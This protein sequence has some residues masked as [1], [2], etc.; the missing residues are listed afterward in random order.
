MAKDKIYEFE[1]KYYSNTDH[2]LDIGDDKWGGD[3]YDLFW[4]A[5]HGSLKADLC[6]ETVYYS[7]SNPEDV[8]TDADELVEDYFEDSE[9]S[10][11]DMIEKEGEQE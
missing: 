9:V 7:A 11:D 3:L 2:S 6:E 8:Y 4:D 1:G 10:Y 5:S